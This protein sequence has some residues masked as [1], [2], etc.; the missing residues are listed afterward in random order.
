MSGVLR[1]EQALRMGVLPA[2]Y[3]EL[4][5]INKGTQSITVAF[6]GAQRQFEW[7]EISLIYDKSFQHLTIYDSYDLELATKLIQ[8]IK[9]QSTTS[10]HSLMGKIDYNQTNHDCKKVLYQMFVAYNCNGCST[11]PLTQYKNISRNNTRRR[12]WQK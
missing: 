1:S 8:E 10:T 2:P 11:A 9:F 5:E 12:I 4:F 7:F 6:K 3:Q